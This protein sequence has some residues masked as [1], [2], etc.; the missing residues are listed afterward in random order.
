MWRGLEADVK[1][2]LLSEEGQQHG[3]RVRMVQRYL[4][5]VVKK[6]IYI[7]TFTYIQLGLQAKILFYY[8]SS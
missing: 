8:L 6:Y 5:K 3:F 4:V 1:D 7:N 2:T